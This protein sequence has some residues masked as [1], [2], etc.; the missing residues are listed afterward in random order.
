MIYQRALFRRIEIG[1]KSSLEMS[2]FASALFLQ[3]RTSQKEIERK[4][5][6]KSRNILVKVIEE[7]AGLSSNRKTE[8]NASSEAVEEDNSISIE[9]EKVVFDLVAENIESS[10][11]SSPGLN[12]SLEMVLWSAKKTV[13][14]LSDACPKCSRKYYPE[15]VFTTWK[16]SEDSSQMKCANQSCKAVFRSK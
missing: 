9:E 13:I 1:S 15:E 14:F 10:E 2:T 7:E 5:R 6:Q 4:K 16:R 8:R 3:A 11:R 12:T